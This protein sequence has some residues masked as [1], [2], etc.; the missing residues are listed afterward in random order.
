M[1]LDVL[2]SENQIY[3]GTGGI[4]KENYAKGFEPA[5]LDSHTGI[6]YRS[7][8]IDGRPAP[9]HVMDGLPN[10]LV[11]KRNASGVVIAIK[12]GVISG[13]VLDVFFIRGLRQQVL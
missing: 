7:C 6:I 11:T 1:N 10:N 2:Q 8:F 3:E 9:V 4:S 5:F 13:L 12:D